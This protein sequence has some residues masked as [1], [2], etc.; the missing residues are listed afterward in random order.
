MTSLTSRSTRRIL[1]T[2]TV[3]GGGGWCFAFSHSTP[4]LCAAVGID[5]RPLD[6]AAERYLCVSHLYELDHAG[7]PPEEP[8]KGEGR[9]YVWQKPG[10]E[11]GARNDAAVGDY[12]V[13]RV[14]VCWIAFGNMGGRGSVDGVECMY[15]ATQSCT[16][17]LH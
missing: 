12:V 2:R 3:C 8:L 11:V 4:C 9:H 10:A 13:L 6:P 16:K 5:S 7:R 14:L 15:P 1:N 17:L